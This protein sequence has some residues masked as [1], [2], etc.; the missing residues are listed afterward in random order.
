M[1]K[2]IGAG[3]GRTGTLSLKCTLEILGFGPCYHSM[4]VLKRPHHDQ[5]WHAALTGSSP[6]WDSVFDGFQAAV[7]W[8]SAFFWQELSD[9]YPDAKIILTVRDEHAGYESIR[10]TIFAANNHCDART[11]NRVQRTSVDDP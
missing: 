7:D 10:Q 4:E 2:V 6:V 9:T 11:R 5:I 8:P 3:F 1:L